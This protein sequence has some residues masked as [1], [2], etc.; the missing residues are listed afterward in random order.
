[1]V[2][3]PTIPGYEILELVGSGGSSEVYLA[4]QL[5]LNRPVA[6]KLL[7][8]APAEQRI[9]QSARFQREAELL[10]DVSCPHIVAVF[11]CGVTQQLPFLVIEFVEGSTL[12]EHLV[13]GEPMEWQRAWTILKSVHEAVAY[14]HTRGILHRDIKPE[15]VLL[16]EQGNVKLGDLGI[17]SI[18]AEVGSVTQSGQFVGTIDYMAPEQRHRLPVDG[19]SDLFSLAVMAYEMLTGHKP[20]GSFKPPSTLNTTLSG[21]VDAV[22]LRGLQRDADDRYETVPEYA[23]ALDKSF[24]EQNRT[25][26]RAAIC[27]AVAICSFLAIAGYAAAHLT[28]SAPYAPTTNSGAAAPEANVSDSNTNNFDSVS[29]D[30]Q[31]RPRLTAEELRGHTVVELRAIAKENA[32]T[33]YSKLRKA[34]LIEL[35]VQGRNQVSLPSGWSTRVTTDSLGRR[36]RWFISSDGRKFRK[37]PAEVSDDESESRPSQPADDTRD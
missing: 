3:A 20:I 29:F 23:E 10:A 31:H 6:I 27:L 24:A 34:E 14:L 12:R 5:S 2:D 33:G 37:P 4:R 25:V 22:I 17:A 11:D 28:K 7:D 21:A 13:D 35:I 26:N 9:E 1:M 36:I 19:R 18:G 15:N 30:K 16:D 8:A 32:L